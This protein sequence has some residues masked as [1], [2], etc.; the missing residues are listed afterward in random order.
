MCCAALSATFLSTANERPYE[1]TNETLTN[2]RFTELRLRFGFAESYAACSD[3]WRGPVP[4]S[5]SAAC[6]YLTAPP[7][8]SR[9]SEALLVQPALQGMTRS[10]LAYC[11]VLYIVLSAGSVSGTL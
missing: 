11:T 9:C 6:R 5:P 3:Y 8:G 7:Q 2:M 10:S 4:K 1:R